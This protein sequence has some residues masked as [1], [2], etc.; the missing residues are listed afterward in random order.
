MHVFTRFPFIFH[1]QLHIY[2]CMHTVHITRSNLFAYFS[3]FSTGSGTTEN[4]GIYSTILNYYNSLIYHIYICVCT[5]SSW[6]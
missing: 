3:Q 4:E 5:C 6:E 1:T 2:T